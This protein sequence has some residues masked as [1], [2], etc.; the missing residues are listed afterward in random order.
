MPSKNELSVLHYALFTD[1][2][3]A[4]SASR[5]PTLLFQNRFLPPKETVVDKIFLTFYF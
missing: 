2:P 3:Q 1:G 4:G 5:P